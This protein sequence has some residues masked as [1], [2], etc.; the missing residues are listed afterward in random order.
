M[1]RI[2]IAAAIVAATAASPA[3]AADVGLSISI[4]QPGFYGQ[5]DIGDFPQPQLIY[6]QPV[7]IGHGSMNRPP[8]YLHV[9]PGHAKHWRKHCRE[10][11]ACGERVYFVHDNW[12]ERE[13]VPRYREQHRGNDEERRNEH[14][15]DGRGNNRNVHRGNEND[16]GREHVRDR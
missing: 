2:Y 3:I 9:P 1:K 5:L 7:M 12:Y 6:A 15:T 10:Y 14:Q 13:Y 8:I 11:N 16:N 4:G